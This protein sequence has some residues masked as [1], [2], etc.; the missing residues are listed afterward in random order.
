ME[1]EIIEIALDVIATAAVVWAAWKHV[2]YRESDA[3][4]KVRRAQEVARVAMKSSS[5]DVQKAAA[6]FRL[7]DIEEDGKFDWNDK[8][9]GEFLA[10]ARKEL[11]REKQGS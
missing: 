3:D 7:F 9:V 10:A 6:I 2:K 1:I 4:V 11:E 8:Q 5:G